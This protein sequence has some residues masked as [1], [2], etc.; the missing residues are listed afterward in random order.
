MRLWFVRGAVL[1]LGLNLIAADKRLDEARLALP[2]FEPPGNVPGTV[3]PPA[4]PPSTAEGIE[5]LFAP[6]LILVK[7]VRVT[8]NTVLS[9]DELE[10]IISH[11]RGRRLSFAD[12]ERIRDEITRA[13]IRHGYVSSGAVIPDQ[14]IRDGTVE[15]AVM[16]GRLGTIE[17]KTEGRLK[18]SYID[19][20][21]LPAVSGVVNVSR[22]EEA[23]QLLRQNPR[24]GTVEAELIPGDVRGESVLRVRV[25]A[26]Q[27]SSVL[28]KLDNYQPLTVGSTRAAGAAL[29]R[30]VS[31]RGDTL[32]AS[33]RATHGLR[34][35]NAAYELPLN[36]RE[37][38]LTL[39]AD[40]ARS[41]VVEGAFAALDIKSRLESYG[42]TL[43]HPAYRTMRSE[44]DV[45]V[46]GELRRSQSFL[47]GSGFQFSDDLAEDGS[48][49]A[50]VVRLGQ[51]WIRSG[52][53]HAFAVRNT[54]GIG[55]DAFGATPRGRNGTERRFV[56]WLGQAQWAR[57]FAALGPTGQLIFRG[58]VQLANASLP[59]LEK[60]ALGGR[61][62]VRGYREN[63]L[64]RDNGLIGS[65][66]ARI[67]LLTRR[68]G[69]IAAE[70]A[71][72][73]DA[74]RS[75]NASGA[76][77]TLPGAGIGLACRMGKRLQGEIYWGH[78]FRGLERPGKWSLQNS[79]VHA[80]LSWRLE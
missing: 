44:L 68:G 48:A 15:I 73:A 7:D 59:G 1:A 33:L 3:L 72:F 45:F 56:S 13:Q 62:T 23:L 57:R 18:P 29:Y 20:R 28:V 24:I 50:S 4:A 40:T 17:A 11:Y 67:T 32:S 61:A 2:D 16:E 78:A 60:F 52:K 70:I 49:R 53:R 12:L 34:S 19:R 71:P 64:V 76:A 80:G 6:V 5:G 79:G 10:A 74:G 39:H 41:T 21:L 35:M 69:S 30:N 51:S 8:G 9:P 38:T 27:L 25:E 54:V 37:T 75:W 63:E 22:I 47:L 77:E 58:D 65:V 55:L 31:G 26:A 36:A 42:F 46:T 14:T 43:L 66:E